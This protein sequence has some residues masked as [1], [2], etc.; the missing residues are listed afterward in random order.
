MQ[1]KLIKKLQ[2]NCT[3]YSRGPDDQIQEY[4][5]QILHSVRNLC[6][7]I[8]AKFVDNDVSTLSSS[9]SSRKL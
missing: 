2:G 4:N 8:K 3:L 1:K 7:L 5:N 6:H 9:A